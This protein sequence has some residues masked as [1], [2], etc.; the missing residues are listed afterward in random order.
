MGVRVF[1]FFFVLSKS[2]IFPN[3]GKGVSVG[4]GE[5]VSPFSNRVIFGEGGEF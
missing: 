4:G 2:I 5:W 1:N 3:G